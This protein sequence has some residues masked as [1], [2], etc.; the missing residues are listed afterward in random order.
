MT[1]RGAWMVAKWLGLIAAGL[2]AVIFIYAGW[3][4]YALADKALDWLGEHAGEL[5]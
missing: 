5:E 4:L 1:L 3:A 2:L